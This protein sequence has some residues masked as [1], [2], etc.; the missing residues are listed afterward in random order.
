MR[1]AFSE[2]QVDLRQAIRQ[3]LEAE[4]TPA[5]VRQ[6]MGPPGQPPGPRPRQRWAVL[7]DLGATGLVIPEPAGLGLGWVE[8]AAV[9]EEAGWAALPEP[10]A[11][12]AG[13]AA[14]LLAHL[15]PAQQADPGRWLAAVAG[16]EAIATVGG[17]EV[18]PSGWELTTVVS[19][20]GVAVTPRVPAAGW[21][22][23]MV[24]VCPGEPGPTVHLVGADSLE[25]QAVPTLDPT[26]E[27][28]QVTWRPASATQVAEGP[29]A[30]A[31]LDQLVEQASVATAAVLVG[32]AGRLIDLSATYAT[33]RQQF[34]RPIG[35][36]QA[37]K[38]QLANAR[39]RLE[40]ARPAL[41][42]AAWSLEHSP[43]TARHD[44]AMAKALASDCATLAARTAIQVHG[45]IGYTWECDVQLWAKRTWA[46]A[47]AWGDA[48]TQRARVLHEVLRWEAQGA[49]T[50]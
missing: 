6:A 1:F 38:H 44:A 20:D 12:S 15:D 30:L 27:L 33:E 36:F 42:R 24:L 23:V 16:G 35:S 19:G 2:S 41:Y 3:V 18:T 49:P 25:R 43:A 9:L 40:F 14:P 13:L 50:P 21:A 7:A 46:L 48:L 8:L 32:L 11:E 37:V 26:R 17:V 34:G 28:A 4:C 31:A 22:D 29:A 47:A 39:V 5:E 10:L 45:A